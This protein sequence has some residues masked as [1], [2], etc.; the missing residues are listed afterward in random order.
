MKRSLLRD[1]GFLIGVAGVIVA[2]D[3]WTKY[4]VRTYLQIGETWVPF[5][6]LRPYARIVHWNNT[7]AAFGIFP[8][9]GGIFT[10]IAVLVIGAILYYFPQIPRQ[11]VASR[12]ALGL[13]LGG[14]SGNL[15][16]RLYHGPVTDFVSVGSFAVFNVADS[17]ISIGAVLLVVAMWVE[18]RRNKERAGADPVDENGNRNLEGHSG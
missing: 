10:V 7:G 14:A 12:I 9:G 15:L 13:Q 17:C 4:L 18:E 11:Q 6:W 2:L 3:Q 5:D 1:Y 16:D 8:S